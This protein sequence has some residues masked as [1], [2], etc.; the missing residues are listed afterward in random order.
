MLSCHLFRSKAPPTNRLRFCGQELA[1][2]NA[3]P[4]E[5]TVQAVA[6]CAVSIRRLEAGITGV[7]Y[8]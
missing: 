8:A 2:C 1:A 5:V 3:R 7:G 4:A 6:D